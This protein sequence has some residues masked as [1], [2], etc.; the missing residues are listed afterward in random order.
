MYEKNEQLVEPL[1][2]NR[3]IDVSIATG[4]NAS[5]LREELSKTGNRVREGVF[6]ERLRVK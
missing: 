5:Q 1:R 2:S 3:N 6:S 4:R